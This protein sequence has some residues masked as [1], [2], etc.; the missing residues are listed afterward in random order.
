MNKILTFLYRTR[1]SLLFVPSIFIISSFVLFYFLNTTIFESAILKYFYQEHW[2]GFIGQSA[3]NLL[4][5]ANNVVVTIFA[6]SISLTMIVLT[7]VSGQIGPRI[8][9]H[10]LGNKVTQMILGLYLGTIL[11]LMLLSARIGSETPQDQMPLLAI[12]FGY[13]FVIISPALMVY[14]IQHL[15]SSII[16][17]N[18]VTSLSDS[19][20]AAVDNYLKNEARSGSSTREQLPKFEHVV[21]LR[22]KSSGYLSNIKETSLV[23]FLAEQD[24]MLDFMHLPGRFI[25]EGAEIGKVY[26]KKKQVSAEEIEKIENYIEFSRQ[27]P[28]I[29]DVEFFLRQIVEIA[30]RALSPGI[31]DPY[32]A[33][34]CINYMFKSLQRIAL[35]NQLPSGIY[36]DDKNRPRLYRPFFTLENMY[37]LALNEIQEATISHVNTQIY[38]L[39]IIIVTLSSPINTKAKKH[40]ILHAKEILKGIKK[41]TSYL[42]IV[43]K[44]MLLKNELKLVCKE[45][46]I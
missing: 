38:I 3:Y 26:S 10:F 32:T 23:A 6:L 7:L 9:D 34:A 15:A 1:Q 16:P 25:I 21:L 28:I 39:E 11:F 29:K 45:N 33:H 30:L 13:I 35:S 24:Y 4:G 27:I 37:D 12:T 2:D 18:V 8:M 36:F 41:Q 14:F 20:S 46:N 40:L 43:D 31:N 22:S 19:L 17:D 5:V 42:P 44:L